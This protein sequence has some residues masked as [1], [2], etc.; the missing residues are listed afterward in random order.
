MK[1]E[2][3]AIESGEDLLTG[4]RYRPD[5]TPHKTGLVLAHGFTSGKYS[6]DGLA[7]YL[8]GQGYECLT[9]D[10]VGHKLGGSGGRMERTE[11]AAENLRDAVRYFCRA[12]DCRQVI[13]IG[14]SMGAAAAIQAAAWAAHEH[15]SADS[16]ISGIIL[17]CMGL[18]PDSGFDS[19]AGSA[20]LKQRSDYVVGAEGIELLRGLNRLLEAA[21]SLAPLPTLVIAAKNDLLLPVSKVEALAARIGESAELRTIDA[22]HL[23]APDRSRGLIA[24]WLAAH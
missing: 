22:M 6:L 7:G 3:V 20:M 16:P 8:A 2:Q 23:D 21:S 19:I 11:Q 1:L 24:N 17:I 4:L 5:K 14:H 13:L 18:N 10:T 12:T 15:A 9:F